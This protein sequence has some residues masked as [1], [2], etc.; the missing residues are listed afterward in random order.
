MPVS[1][2]GLV[3]LALCSCEGGVVFCLKAD[4]LPFGLLFTLVRGRLV[5]IV[6]LFSLVNVGLLLF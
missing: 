2:G 5:V 1:T 4:I 3:C 6:K